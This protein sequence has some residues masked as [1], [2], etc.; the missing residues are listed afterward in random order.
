LALAVGCK[1]FE[2]VEGDQNCDYQLTFLDDFERRALQT[3]MGDSQ[4]PGSA[5]TEDAGDWVVDHGNAVLTG[6]EE[7]RASSAHNETGYR[8]RLSFTAT[9]MEP[10]DEAGAG[11]RGVGGPGES[12]VSARIA[13]SGGQTGIYEGGNQVPTLDGLSP[14]LGAG[15]YYV[16]LEVSEASAVLRITQDNYAAKGG[17]PYLEFETDSLAES[18]DGNRF[19]VQLNDTSVSIGEVMLEACP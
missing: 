14:E 10:S 12:G 19:F 5:W 17:N 16:E 11:F 9:L 8:A 7:S 15:E 4:V 1:S 3:D 13:R 6:I 2:K 18:E